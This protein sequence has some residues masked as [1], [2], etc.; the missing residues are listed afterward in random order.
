MIA[1]DANLAWCFFWTSYWFW[2]TLFTILSS[3]PIKR[4]NTVLIC[5]LKNMLVTWIGVNLIFLQPLRLCTHYSPWLKLL[6]CIILA[7][8]W[9]YHIHIMLHQRQ[10]FHL[11]HAQHHEFKHPYAL[12]GI[13]C[14][15]YEAFVCNLLSVSLGPSLTDLTG[16]W[17]YFWVILAGFNVTL[18]H[19]G[20]GLSVFGYTLINSSHDLHHSNTNFNYGTLDVWD[21]I[22]STFRN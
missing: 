7:E 15:S 21:N 22:Y 17:L 12:T 3:R 8:T 13:Y 6:L 5:V 9:F 18:A 19:S 1:F 2:G 20:F 4:L 14:S 10:L 16:A 11:F